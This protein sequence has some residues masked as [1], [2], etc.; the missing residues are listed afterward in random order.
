MYKRQIDVVITA[1]VVVTTTEGVFEALFELRGGRPSALSAVLPRARGI[2][3]AC[4]LWAELAS[5]DLLPLGTD[6]GG[7]AR[8]NAVGGAVV[9]AVVAT[10]ITTVVTA[11]VTAT[12]G[13]SEALLKLRGRSPSA[14]P[15]G[16]PFAC[17]AAVACILG[18]ELAGGVAHPRG[19]NM[20]GAT[21]HNAVGVVAW[22]AGTPEPCRYTSTLLIHVNSYNAWRVNRDGVN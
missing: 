5:G 13:V 7:A 1:V 21:C 8:H 6:V 9:A 11:V 17:G 4:I 3:V 2:T 20:G 18:A 16:L 15:T 22:S 10:V 19:T 14:R 12:D